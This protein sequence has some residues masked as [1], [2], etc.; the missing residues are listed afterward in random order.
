[1]Y[2]TSDLDPPRPP[3]LENLAVGTGGVRALGVVAV[4]LPPE[5]RLQ[6]HLGRDL[7]VKPG[8]HTEE[9]DRVVEVGGMDACT[10]DARDDLPAALEV[11]VVLGLAVLAIRRPPE[12]E[13][14]HL[15]IQVFAEQ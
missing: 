4:L 14:A 9:Q 12:Y 11:R 2:V 1:M 15:G 8:G 13:I 10:F 5:I 7:P 6:A 3:E